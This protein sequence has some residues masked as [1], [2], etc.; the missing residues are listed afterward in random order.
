[1]LPDSSGEPEA[2]AAD[3]LHPAARSKGASDAT[4][5]L[6][7]QIINGCGRCSHSRERSILSRCFLMGMK[8]SSA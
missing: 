6:T 7:G 3:L 8:S 1:M 2:C 4:L 5:Q